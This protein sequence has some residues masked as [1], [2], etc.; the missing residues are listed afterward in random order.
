MAAPGRAWRKP[1]RSP[2]QRLVS[3]PHRPPKQKGR[4]PCG[5]RPRC[6][7]ARSEEHTS[8]LQSLMRTSYAV[9]CLKQKTYK[10]QSPTRVMSE[11]YIILHRSV[12]LKHEHNLHDT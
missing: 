8:E 2:P 1:R 9:F 11:I 10:T 6:S 5:S 3:S 4:L 12:S 7:F